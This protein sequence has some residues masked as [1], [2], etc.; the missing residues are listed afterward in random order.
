MAELARIVWGES[1]ASDAA[2]ADALVSRIDDLCRAV[3]VPRRLREIDVSREQIPALVQAS[4][5]NSLDGNPVAI[6]DEQ[7]H[8]ILEQ[9]W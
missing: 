3:G 9:M 7:L 4:H 8:T 1:W 5:G 2:A 6:G